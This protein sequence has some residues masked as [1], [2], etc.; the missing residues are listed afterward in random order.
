MNAFAAGAELKVRTNVLPSFV[1]EPS[2][3]SGV[4]DVVVKAVV[5]TPSMVT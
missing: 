1:V 3:N 5:G 4:V 2:P